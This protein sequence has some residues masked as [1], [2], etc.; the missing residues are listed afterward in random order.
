MI[1][2]LHLASVSDKCWHFIIQLVR[3]YPHENP[4]EIFQASK[5]AGDHRHIISKRLKITQP[6]RTQLFLERSSTIMPLIKEILAYIKL[7]KNRDTVQVEIAGMDIY[8]PIRDEVKSFNREDI[9]YW[10]VDDDYDGAS[11]I[12]KQ[13]FF[14]GSDDEFLK[15]S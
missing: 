5:M 10:M 14:C 4:L 12:V 8:D 3:F 11:F 15:E 13:V 2:T 9:A 6:Q 1:S 7:H